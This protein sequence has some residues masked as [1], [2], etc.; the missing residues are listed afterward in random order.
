MLRWYVNYISNPISG[1]S[2]SHTHILTI[3]HHRYQATLAKR[4][5]L[6][7]S[8]GS[9]LLF[10]TG[11]ILAQQAVDQVGL[12]NHNYARTGRM[13]LYGGAIFGPAATTWYKFLQRNVVM[14]TPGRTLVARVGADQLIFAPT[15][16]FAFLSSMSI[17]EGN[18]P[19]EK[20]RS[21]Y[22]TGYKANLMIWPW[23]QAVNFRFVPL[24]HRVLVVN[25]VSLGWNCLLSLINSGK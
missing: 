24:E 10:G 11:D 23:V 16:M 7:Q 15:H 25:T 6:T 14:S 12:E 21:S 1:A 2:R 13:A 3:F 9:A 17:L 8:I 4:P 18:D 20:L 5:L 22:W 19:L